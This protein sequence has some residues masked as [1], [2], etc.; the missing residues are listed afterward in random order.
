MR[1]GVKGWLFNSAHT[2]TLYLEDEGYRYK[3][4]FLLLPLSD[5]W[6]QK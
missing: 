3:T 5:I 2:S 4:A 6:F 1:D